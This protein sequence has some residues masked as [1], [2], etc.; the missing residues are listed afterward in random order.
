MY[1]GSNRADRIDCYPNLDKFD[2]TSE[3]C[4][5]LCS[6]LVRVFS[7][8]LQSVLQP[9]STFSLV[10]WTTFMVSGRGGADVPSQRSQL[11][12]SLYATFLQ[13]LIVT[14]EIGSEDIPILNLEPTENTL[15]LG[16]KA[17]WNPLTSSQQENNTCIARS[18]AI[19]SITLLAAPI[20]AIAQFLWDHALTG[21]FKGF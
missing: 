7:F 8:N 15:I 3:Q 2:F 4:S 20:N 18:V 14:L 17:P 16:I 19:P 10:P 21:K 5:T 6:I 11:P 13:A 9:H 12:E 1:R